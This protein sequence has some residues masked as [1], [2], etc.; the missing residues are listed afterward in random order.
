MYN[1]DE[2]LCE[3]TLKPV[4]EAGDGGEGGVGE[5]AG[6]VAAEEGLGVG[7]DDAVGVEMLV[8]EDSGE[9]YAARFYGFEREDGVVD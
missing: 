7:A 5:V 4:S 1:S 8:V 9:L 2:E 6:D 3:I